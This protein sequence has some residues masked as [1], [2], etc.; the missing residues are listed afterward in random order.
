L[1]PHVSDDQADLILSML[2]AI[3]AKQDE[4]AVSLG[5]IREVIG[6]IEAQCSSISRRMERSAGNPEPGNWHLIGADAPDV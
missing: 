3:R 6:L 4:Q 1:E 5:E 2:K